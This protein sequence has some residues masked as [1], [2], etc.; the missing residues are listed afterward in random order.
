MLPP[1]VA[2][3]FGTFPAELVAVCRPHPWAELARCPG[4]CR[5]PSQLPQTRH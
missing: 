3:G 1:L 4:D 2:D 5:R